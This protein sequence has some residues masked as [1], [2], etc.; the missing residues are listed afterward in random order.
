[1]REK[2]WAFFGKSVARGR[3]RKRI[4]MQDLAA[5][6]GT[7]MR[8]V[9]EIEHGQRFPDEMTLL[10]LIGELELTPDWVFSLQDDSTAEQVDSIIRLIKCFDETE[11]D[12][13]QCFIRDLAR[14]QV[15]AIR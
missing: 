14:E 13:I 1:M 8:E 4:S 7:G 2:T 11:L 12:Q 9:F 5:R 15:R 10:R 6:L 3:R